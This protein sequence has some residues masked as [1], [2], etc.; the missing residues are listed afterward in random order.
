MCYKSDLETTS[1]PHKQQESWVASICMWCKSNLKIVSTPCGS[2]KLGLHPLVCGANFRPKN[3]ASTPW[4][5]ENWAASICMWCKWDLKIALKLKESINFDN[6]WKKST[7]IFFSVVFTFELTFE[8][9]KEFGYVSKTLDITNAS[10]NFHELLK[11]NIMKQ[12]IKPKIPLNQQL[13]YKAN[14]STKL[15]H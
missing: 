12:C 11:I 3:C 9:F 14:S 2:K 8:S 10:L 13:S 15:I 7:H 4:Q 5:Q 1:T 6:S